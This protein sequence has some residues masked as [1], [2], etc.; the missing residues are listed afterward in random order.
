MSL[1]SD[2]ITDIRVELNDSDSTRW[3]TDTPILAIVKQAI[4]RANRICQRHGLAFAR[5]SASLTTTA[6]QAY[7]S[8]PSDFDI[9]IG[10]YRDD[11]HVPI[12]KRTED[13][14]ERIVSAAAIEN[15]YLDM[16]NSRI[17]WNGTPTS[18]IAVTLWYYPT[19]DPSAYTTAS[20]MP[21]S[22]RLDDMI[23]RYVAMRMQN[24]DE[25]TVTVDMA[26]LTDME[27]SII[28]TYRPLSQTLLPAG[29][30]MGGI[31]T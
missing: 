4:R 23:A 18:E 10:L 19:V 2:V 7:T 30:W 14:W 28:E 13:E 22:G 11:T 27:N 6:D 1:V 25:M 29:G 24:I 17:N 15:W 5:K 16:V 3:T 21:W 26:I 8:L 12:T 20:T 31:D 9:D